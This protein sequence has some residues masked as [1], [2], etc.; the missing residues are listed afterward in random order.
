MNTTFYI[1][2]K[3]NFFIFKNKIFSKYKINNFLIYKT[4]SINRHIMND[5]LRA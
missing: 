1:N 5:L 2:E 4:L 3:L